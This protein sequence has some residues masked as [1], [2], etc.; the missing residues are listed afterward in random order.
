MAVTD[1]AGMADAALPP[2]YGSPGGGSATTDASPSCQV[3]RFL[4]HATHEGSGLWLM[5]LID[6]HT[7]QSL[8]IRVGHHLEEID[9]A[10]TLPAAMLMRAVPE[11]IRL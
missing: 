4:H 9:V 7:R 5:T 2:C 10:D 8:V 11:Y 6:A 3:V 1:M